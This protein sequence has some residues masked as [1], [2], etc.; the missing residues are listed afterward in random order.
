MR[1][2][3]TAEAWMI[4]LVNQCQLLEGQL[5]EL[6]WFPANGKMSHDTFSNL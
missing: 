1:G 6:P 4:G 5:N 2:S 3:I